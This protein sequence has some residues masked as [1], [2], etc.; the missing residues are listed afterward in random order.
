MISDDLGIQL[1]DKVTRGETLSLAQ[2]D[3]LN[4]WYAAQDLAEQEQLTLPEQTLDLS[5]LQS[6]IEI[7]LNQINQATQRIQ[8]VT[9][10]NQRLRAEI[11]Q[12]QK[13]VAER[14]Q[15]A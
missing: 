4:E 11:N 13:L 10:E 9:S 3:Q 2:Q 7:S 1:H 8:E 12:L 14:L 15:P 6:Q 5:K